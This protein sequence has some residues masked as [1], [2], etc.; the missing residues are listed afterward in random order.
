MT[1][2]KPLKFS[3][4]GFGISETGINNHCH[5]EFTHGALQGK[6]NTFEDKLLIVD[7]VVIFVVIRS[8]ET[9]CLSHLFSHDLS[10]LN[11]TVFYFCGLF[12]LRPGA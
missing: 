4:C 10:S 8:T 1:L 11:W 6:K 9:K 7:M 3:R 2:S 5:I 12:F